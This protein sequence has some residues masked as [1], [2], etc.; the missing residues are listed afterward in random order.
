MCAR[1]LGLQAQ[2][3]SELDWA[4][5]IAPYFTL[6]GLTDRVDALLAATCGL[7]LLPADSLEAAAAV[8]GLSRAQQT[9]QDVIKPQQQQQD[10]S[11]HAW[12]DNVMHLV[13]LDTDWQQQQ[14]QPL[15]LGH[16]FIELVP[17][18]GF[19]SCCLL[20]LP[21][22]TASSST[23]N[24][25]ANSNSCSGSSNDQQ[26]S[27]S[28]PAYT[29]GS[30]VIRLPIP[31]AKPLLGFGQRSA[32][33]S[34]TSSTTISTNSQAVQQQQQQQQQQ[35]PV[36]LMLPG[37]AALQALLHELGHALSYLCPAAHLHTSGAETLRHTSSGTG[38]N[39][40]APFAAPT[41][42][43]TNSNKAINRPAAA[44]AAEWPLHAPLGPHCCCLLSSPAA[45][46]DVREL[47][48]HLL[49]HH[50]RHPASLMVRTRWSDCYCFGEVVMLS[51]Q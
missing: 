45:G 31:T 50:V 16:V 40:D 43:T 24:S 7:R 19:P 48:S 46:L 8:G 39:S 49:E 14:Q 5:D 13:L 4:R 27:V 29:P 41:S 51:W 26:A 36:P 18:W 9:E 30:V 6:P 11:V 12:G 34:S 3:L 47:S 21:T 28:Q 22:P 2:H 25:I 17:G 42:H 32:A 35:E 44:A 20:Q 23:G 37:P 1:L 10:G 15:L 33:G 38:N